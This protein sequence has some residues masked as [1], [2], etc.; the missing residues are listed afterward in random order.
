M[1][2]TGT[3]SQTPPPTTATT[4]KHASS[5]ALWT[6]QVLRSRFPV[7][8]RVISMR[9]VTAGLFVLLDSVAESPNKWKE[10]LCKK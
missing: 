2:S 10:I 9:K 8:E 4:R 5:I 1:S 6:L 7:E 3:T